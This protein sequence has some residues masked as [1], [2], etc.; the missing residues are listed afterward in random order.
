MAAKSS[1]KDK[2]NYAFSFKLFAT[3]PIS[4]Q[5]WVQNNK[6]GMK[7]EFE[8][9]ELE[10]IHFQN[11]SLKKAYSPFFRKDI[12][13][14]LLKRISHIKKIS[15]KHLQTPFFC[16]HLSRVDFLTD[17]FLINCSC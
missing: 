4:I 6:S 13:K 16:G 12:E 14:E 15:D 8:P 9:A 1:H 11:I 10:N 3:K 17:C 7:T 2:K 5:Y